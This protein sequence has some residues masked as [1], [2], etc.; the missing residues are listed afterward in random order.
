MSSIV[1]EFEGFQFQ[2]DSSVIKELAFHSVDY[3]HHGCWTFL[4]PLPWGQLSNKNRKTFSWMT[5]YCHGLRWE[6]GEISYTFLSLILTFLLSSHSN[7][8]TKGLEK[9]NFLEKLS[10]RKVFDLNEFDCPKISTFE[11]SPLKC[12]SHKQSFKHCAVFKAYSYSSFIKEKVFST[13]VTFA[14][15]VS[16]AAS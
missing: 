2:T 3:G 1:I 16:S 8:Y 5:R 14:H 4:P 15:D 7:I 11:K 10:G 12:P 13:P 6:S 9:K